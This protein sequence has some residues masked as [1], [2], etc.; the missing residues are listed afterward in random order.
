MQRQQKRK[1]ETIQ[2][3]QKKLNVEINYDYG[4]Y[5]SHKTIQSFIDNGNCNFTI[6]I[7]N[8]GM[9]KIND[10]QKGI[11]GASKEEYT[12][13]AKDLD[14]TNVYFDEGNSGSSE[15]TM[16]SL[17]HKKN[18]LYKRFFYE[19]RSKNK[20]ITCVKEKYHSI[21]FLK[22]NRCILSTHEDNVIIPY[23]LSPRSD[24]RPRVIKAMKHLIRTCGGK[25]ELF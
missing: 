17:E 12:F 19:P 4:D 10:I 25:G 16:D 1:E 20:K 14:P 9:E 7:V 24:N 23:L 5:T 13:N 18:I 3:I 2:F 6:K 22:S 21:K 8:V 11:Y 15:I